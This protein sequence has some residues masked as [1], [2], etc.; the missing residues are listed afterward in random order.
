LRP[1]PVERNCTATQTDGKLGSLRIK[2]DCDRL[3][4]EKIFNTN[5]HNALSCKCIQY[6]DD[7]SRTGVIPLP[8]TSSYLGWHDVLDNDGPSP[9]PKFREATDGRA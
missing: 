2:I 5:A 3:S 4:V 7:A 1:P 6:S 9:R 8:L